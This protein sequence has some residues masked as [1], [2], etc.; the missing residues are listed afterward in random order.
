MKTKSMDRIGKALLLATAGMLL[1]T[2]AQAQQAVARLKQVSGNVLVTREAGMATGTEAQP[3]MQGARVITTANSE[4]VVVFDNGCEVRLKE[5]QRLEVDSR[6]PCA[7][8]VVQSL[9]VPPAPGA[10]IAGYV[11]PALIG[12]GVIAGGGSGGGPSPPNPISPN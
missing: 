3:I 4:A 10:P 12:I 9:G 6:K 7:A 11:V 2:G 8:I 5:N 1:A